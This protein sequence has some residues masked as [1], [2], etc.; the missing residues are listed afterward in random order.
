MSVTKEKDEKY[1][2]ISMELNQTICKNLE[3]LLS[4]RNI[5]KRNFCQ[6]LAAE[7]TSVT[8]AYFVKILQ[9]PK[10]ISPAFLLSC[11]DFFGITLQN[12]VSVNFNAEEYIS[13]DSK[14][15]E[16]YLNIQELLSQHERIKEKA[17]R[18]SDVHQE[19]L[20]DLKN[21]SS[22]YL[23]P[24][25]DTEL[26]VDPAHSQ[27][28]GYIQ[29]YYCYYYPTH[30][31]ENKEAKLLKGILRL[32]AKNTYCKA[33]LTINTNTVD[34]NG[35]INYKVYTGYAAISATVNSMNCI[36]YSNAL[37]EFCF[38]MFRHF[39]LN[40]GKQDC[41]IA[42]VLSSSS[43]AE[44]RRPTVLRMFLSKENIRDED[45]KV[46]APSFFSE[47]FDNHFE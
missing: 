29:D 22:D 14:E 12:L 26:I 32:E 42:E 8:R 5:S 36:M 16:D 11:C 35:N 3:A 30:S 46:I 43:A 37:C 7:K 4:A 25:I 40:F 1:E 39:K 15:H 10:Y 45:L 31:S 18:N 44:D 6:Q 9:N 2:K 33:T 24:F 34:D 41:R 47:L 20:Q 17:D 28:A 21:Q 23:Q 38:I 27:F 19:S 13:N